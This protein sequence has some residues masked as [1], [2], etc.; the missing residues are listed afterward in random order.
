[1]LNYTRIKK[2]FKEYPNGYISIVLPDATFKLYQDIN[3]YLDTTSITFKN[4]TYTDKKCGNDY[5]RKGDFVIPFNQIIR[6]EY[7]QQ[8]VER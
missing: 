7:I 5:V 6:I 3:Y 4:I 2:F 8:E 1:M